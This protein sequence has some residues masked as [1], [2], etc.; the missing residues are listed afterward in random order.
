MPLLSLATCCVLN[1]R[2]VFHTP[3]LFGCY[4]RKEYWRQLAWRH[5]RN[6]HIGMAASQNITHVCIHAAKATSI[7][8]IKQG[9]AHSNSQRP[10]KR[11][12]YAPRKPK[13]NEAKS[14]RRTIRTPDAPKGSSP[15]TFQ[16]PTTD[17]TPNPASSQNC[18]H[19]LE[20]PPLT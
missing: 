16:S 18:N 7:T 14:R 19:T 17:R 1:L 9:L 20:Y 12:R 2:V 3:G 11:R 6:D 5:L 4:S 13:T 15:L 10:A 8:I